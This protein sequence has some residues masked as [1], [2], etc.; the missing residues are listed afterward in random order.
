MTELFFFL[1]GVSTRGDEEMVDDR[2]ARQPGGEFESTAGFVEGK[3][4]ERCRSIFHQTLTCWRITGSGYGDEVCLLPYE[5]LW[6]I[7]E[8]K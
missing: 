4:H 8:N 3:Y 7:L 5:N 1:L 2:E 6:S